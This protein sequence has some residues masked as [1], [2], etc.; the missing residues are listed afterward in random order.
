MIVVTEGEAYTPWQEHVDAAAP[1]VVCA[2]FTRSY[3]S[4]AERLLA[5]L[6]ELGLAHALME[7]PTVHRS[8]SPRGN[9]DTTYSK[10]RFIAWALRQFERPILYVDADCVFR[11]QPE[12]LSNL[13]AQNVDFA[14][15]NWLFDVANDAW[16]P[17]PSEPRDASARYWQFGFSV[18]QWSN[19]QLIC[20]GA[21]QYWANTSA[22]HAL[23]QAWQRNLAVYA[24]AVDDQCLDYT[25]NISLSALP[26]TQSRPK[27]LWFPKEYARYAHWPYVRPIIDHPELPAPMDPRESLGEKRFDSTRLLSDPGKAR[28]LPR[29][30]VV[31]ATA[32]LLLMADG[33]GGALPLARL[34][35]ELHRYP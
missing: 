23:L 32:K 5:S 27:V 25:F 24:H 28:P 2:M 35:L 14:I 13:R 12:L 7:V 8:I 33:N 15:Y 21:V 10:P 4:R 26:P 3:L 17:L 34:P 31:D 9:D 22:A 11:G 6:R 30:C 18:E 16:I 20:S 29:M 19:S 1:Y